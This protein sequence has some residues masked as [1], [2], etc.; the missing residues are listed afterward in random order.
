MLWVSKAWG[1]PQL[2]KE[3]LEMVSVKE[4][5]TLML[6]IL[7]ILAAFAL[8]SHVQTAEAGVNGQQIRF[9]CPFM[10]NATVTIIGPNHNGQVVQW[11]RTGVSGWIATWG[12]WWKGWVRVSY[13]NP[14]G[15]V[16]SQQVYVPRVQLYS[17]IFYV[18]C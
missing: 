14:G 5:P 13:R 12:W 8:L 7:L 16:Y 3:G 18:R 15:N 11:Q 4:K 2:E 9:D 10:R 1:V 6:L 17:D